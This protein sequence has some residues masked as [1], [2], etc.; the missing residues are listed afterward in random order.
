MNPPYLPNGS[1]KIKKVF[2]GE[3]LWS[4]NAQ[5]KVYNTKI[6]HLYSGT[7]KDFVIELELGPN[8]V[9]L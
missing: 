5:L 9:I 4:Y 3:D 6:T 8:K 1:V 7:H 2:G